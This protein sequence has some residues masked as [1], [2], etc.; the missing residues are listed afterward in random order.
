[1]IERRE[2]IYELLACAAIIF[3]LIVA[4]WPST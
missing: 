2:I 3:V 4:G 1:M